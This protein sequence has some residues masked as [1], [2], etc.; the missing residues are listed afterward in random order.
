MTDEMMTDDVQTNPLLTGDA[1]LKR[2][3]ETDT[4]DLPEAN[5]S[6]DRLGIKLRIR[7]LTGKTIERIRKDCTISHRDR[8]G[9]MVERLDSDEFSARLVV[10]ATVSPRFDDPALLEA[11]KLSSGAEAVK[12][13]LLAGEYSRVGDCI[14]DLSGFNEEIADVKN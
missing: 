12:R 6:I 14:M 3:I 13:L 5:V 10:T 2:L 8:K 9:N 11:K 7:A 4:D 1:A